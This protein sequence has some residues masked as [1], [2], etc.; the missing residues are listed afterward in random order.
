MTNF[1]VSDS[2]LV[3]L[4]T[5]DAISFE[6]YKAS[7]KNA[8]ILNAH[9][10]MDVIKHPALAYAKR[11]LGKEDEIETGEG[12]KGSLKT[13]NLIDKLLND[14]SLDYFKF[15]KKTPSSAEQKTFV[16]AYMN[17]KEK[18]YRNARE[19]YCASYAYKSKSLAVI[20]AESQ[21]IEKDLEEY[22]NA[23]FTSGVTIIDSEESEMLIEIH[24]S[25]ERSPKFNAI[26]RACGDNIFKEVTIKGKTEF[27]S[28]ECTG[29][30][31]W[32]GVDIA[33][34]IIYIVDY[35]STREAGHTGFGY[36]IN[37]Y[38][39]HVQMAFYVSLIKNRM[40]GTAY[41]D[42]EIIPLWL[43]IRNAAP[44]IV[45]LYKCSDTRLG[46]GR[47]AIQNVTNFIKNVLDDKLDNEGIPYY[48]GIEIAGIKEI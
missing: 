20:E 43:A 3:Q 27:T 1:N 44:H 42:F 11:F 5:V 48:E 21:K 26:R 46:W 47:S 29:R 31:D 39:Y 40:A 35:K 25:V 36:E 34:K 7:T 17:S 23:G 8:N 38:Y 14:G 24:N 32:V 16:R 19:S 30:M 28:I 13:G 18:T 41:Q 12:K 9:F 22:I 45:E 37:R 15:V 6:Q 33:N 4:L 2:S 10:I